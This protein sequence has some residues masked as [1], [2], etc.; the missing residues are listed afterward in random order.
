MNVHTAG[1]DGMNNFNWKWQLSDLEHDKNVKV[2]TTFSCGGVRAWAT[3]E[4]GSK[5]SGMSR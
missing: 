4:P 5:S 2:F 1:L 3:K